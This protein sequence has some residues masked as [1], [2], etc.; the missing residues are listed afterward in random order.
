MKF[1][2]SV[3]HLTEIGKEFFYEMSQGNSMKAP[4][5]KELSVMV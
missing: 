5:K 1:R 3:M 2:K 4:L